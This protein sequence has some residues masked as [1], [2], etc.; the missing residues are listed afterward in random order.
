MQG[1]LQQKQ[2]KYRCF[3]ACAT[4][5]GPVASVTSTSTVAVLK[6]MFCYTYLF[7]QYFKVYTC[8][9]LTEKGALRIKKRSHE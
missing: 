3:L 5:I 1:L 4:E 6:R 8:S 9:L 2:C 7:H